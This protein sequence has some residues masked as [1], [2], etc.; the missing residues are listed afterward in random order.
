MI[1][2][3]PRCGVPSERVEVRHSSPRALPWAGMHRPVGAIFCANGATAYQ[4]RVKP[5]FPIP[6]GGGGM[7]AR[8]CL[9]QRDT[10]YQPRATLWV[11]HAPD[12]RVLKERRMSPNAGRVTDHWYALLRWSIKPC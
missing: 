6:G 4:R 10:A 2:P 5:W 3:C 12:P 1:T 11:G 8:L 7:S 9:S